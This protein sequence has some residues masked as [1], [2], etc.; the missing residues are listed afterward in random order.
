L[1]HFPLVTLSFQALHQGQRFLVFHC[2]LVSQVYL[3]NQ[4]PLV[5]LKLRA[6]R[7]LRDYR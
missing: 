4:M 1:L 6:F 2:F 3:K 5:I 7:L